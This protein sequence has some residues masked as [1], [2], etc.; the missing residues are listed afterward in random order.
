MDLQSMLAT[1]GWEKEKKKR[2]GEGLPRLQVIQRLAQ[3]TPTDEEERLPRSQAILRLASLTRQ[4]PHPR[5]R[6]RVDAVEEIPG[7][8]ETG[9]AVAP[10]AQGGGTPGAPPS[11]GGFRPPPPVLPYKDPRD[12]DGRQP[13]F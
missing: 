11:G 12:E 10:G 6:E 8:R 5:R 13:S 7:T 1:W 2:W 9:T 4:K 3:P